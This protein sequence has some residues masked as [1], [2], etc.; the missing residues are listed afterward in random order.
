MSTEGHHHVDPS[1]KWGQKVG[2]QAAI[3][4]VFLSVF[5]IFAHRAHTETIMAGNA[6]SDEWSHY[7]AK[8]IRDFQ[9]ELAGDM[10]KVT[11][12]GNEAAGKLLESFSKSREKYKE[13]LE[14]I[15]EKAE[16]KE[17]SE[18]IAHRK[19][20]YFDLAEGILELSLVLTS[21]YFLSKKKFFPVLALALAAAGTAVGIF[22]IFLR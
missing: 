16:T 15:R 12:P 11:G 8:R 13:D 6:A 3:L 9:V 19:A 4:A 22:G 18:A 14:E 5:T 10:L 7:Q 1:D 20:S 21:L 17:K 2:L